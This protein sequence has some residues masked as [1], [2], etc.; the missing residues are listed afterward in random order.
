MKSKHALAGIRVFDLSWYG[1]GPFVAKHLA[2]HG[3]EVI[4]VESTLK[5]DA[6]RGAP[7]FKDGIQGENRSGN[8]ANF[9]SSKMSITLNLKHP[10]GVGI[11][12]RVVALCDLVTCNFPVKVLSKWGLTYE[13]LRAVK[14][15]IIMIHM[16][17]M[18]T[19]G[20]HRDYRSHGD[21]LEGVAGVKHLTGWPDGP[22]TG[23]NTPYTDYFV[24]HLFAV[25]ALAALDYRRRTGEGQSI[26]CSQLEGSL[27][28]LE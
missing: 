6:L 8:F 22:P 14:P 3:A 4:R 17:L 13:E 19:T 7:P 21:G 25:A 18:G 12:K 26:D 9:N 1:V 16:S 5:P 11:A 27:C 10:K 23:T 15:D 28:C 20:P 2:D 24:P